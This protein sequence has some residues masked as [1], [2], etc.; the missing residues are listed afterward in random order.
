MENSNKSRWDC[1]GP[2]E[3]VWRCSELEITWVSAF[4]NFDGGEFLTEHTILRRE[5]THQRFFRLT[6]KNGVLLGTLPRRLV[7][8][9]FVYSL[10]K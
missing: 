9:L 3:L 8:G 5:P 2:A 6:G 10:Y 1:V 4:G 7:A